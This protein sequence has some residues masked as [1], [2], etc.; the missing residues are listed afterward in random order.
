M[1]KKLKLNGSMKTYKTMKTKQPK[2]ISFSYA[3]QECKSKKSRNTWRNWHIWPWSTARSRAKANR[4]L[5]REL[6]A[7]EGKHPLPTAGEKIMHGH[8]QMVN[9]ETRLIIFFEAKDG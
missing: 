6:T 3:G 8:Q 1:L 2:K 5:S 9:T 7:L 4:V